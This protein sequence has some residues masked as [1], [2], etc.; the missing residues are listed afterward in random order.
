MARVDIS[1]L[2]KHAE[3]ALNRRN[4]DLAIFNYIQALT[5]QPENIDAR[6]KLRATQSRAASEKGNAS[7]AKMMIPFLKAKV[8]SALRKH[9]QAIISCEQAIT[10]N[11]N[12]T[13][14]MKLLA[15]CA[16][17][18]GNTEMTAVAAWQRREIADK[19]DAEDA[20]NIWELVDLYVELERVA[21][22]MQMLDKIQAISPDDPE[23]E[24]KKKELSAREMS[25]IYQTGVEQGSKAIVAND[26]QRQFLEMDPTKLREDTQRLQYVNYRLEN[27]IKARPDDHRAYQDI[28]DVLF[29]LDDW[30][31][32]YR[33]A[34]KYYDIAH[35]KNPSDN[36][37]L[38]RMGDL[39]LKRMRLELQPLQEACKANP[40]DAEAKKRYAAAR[41][42]ALD[43]ELAEYERRVKAQPL[44]AVFHNRLGELYFQL[45]RYDDAVGE[46]QQASKTPQFKIQALTNLG[47]CFHALEQYDMA[48]EQ[49]RQ[50]REGQELFKKI[51]EPMYYEAL[52]HEA[53]GTAESVKLALQIVTK[54]YQTDIKFRDVKDRVP[55]L[56]KKLKDLGGKA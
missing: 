8:Q 2:L 48:V 25:E 46:L 28:A 21:E 36:T 43:W 19:V 5:L 7:S 42:Q 17:A 10:K 37:V 4:Y 34:K 11:P 30:E 35:Q 14:P 51:V 15:S 56:Q 33:E 12:H 16:K 1:K 26:E 31:T 23:V 54:I 50:A 47:R 45:K 13:G 41:R 22:A 6:T 49:F 44:K 18:I 52:T 9:E 40:Q 3:D 29:N 24:R 32:G 53:I 38:D 20:G 55:A 27:D 39:E